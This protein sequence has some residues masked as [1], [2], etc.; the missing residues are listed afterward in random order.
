MTIGNKVTVLMPFYNA[1]AYLREAIDSI[2][3][4]SY[5]D[6][7][8]LI[9]DD[10][11]T[12][13]S[14]A[15]VE[16]YDDPR[17][18]LLRNDG[19]HGI[20]YTLNRGID[21]SESEYIV[22]MDAD[23]ISEPRR[24]EWQVRFMDSHPEVGASGGNLIIFGEG[25]EPRPFIMNHDRYE[26]R[27]ELLFNSSIP[28]PSAIIRRKV[29]EEYNL[30]YRDEYRGIEDF[31]LWWQIAKHSFITNQNKAILRYRKHRLQTT[32]ND[33]A[34]KEAQLQRA[35]RFISER[36]ADLGINLTDEEKSAIGRYQIGQ[37]DH[38]SIDDITH[39]IDALQKAAQASRADTR[40]LRAIRKIASYAFLNVINAN[41]K[42]ETDWLLCMRYAVDCGVMP[43]WFYLK[44]LIYHKLRR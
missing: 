27:A 40:Q 5:A 44:H 12:D 2:L 41:A 19:N 18:R 21:E 33:R 35:I 39:F 30:R 6:F 42:R 38:L 36:Y 20:C 34:K 8:F 9:I 10:G 14:A 28:H 25:M 1:E 32:I 15:I 26:C 37:T 7:D 4:Q 24:I 17:I 23:D 3:R 13:D 31:E 11:S 16:S 22:R 43:R 29:I